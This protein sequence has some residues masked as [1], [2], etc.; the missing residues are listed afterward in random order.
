MNE[1]FYLRQIQYNLRNFNV[2][3]TDNWRSNYLLNSSVYRVNQLWQ[4]LTS[5]FKDC[6]SLQLFKDKIKTWC[7]DRCQCQICWRYIANVAY[8]QFPFLWPKVYTKQNCIV[9]NCKWPKCPFQLKQCTC[10]L[11]YGRILLA[12]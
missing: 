12:M 3:A 7:C 2:F 8:F 5:K 1:V 6:V 9:V 4:T 11:M 10:R